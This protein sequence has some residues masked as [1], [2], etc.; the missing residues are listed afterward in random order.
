MNAPKPELEPDDR[1]PKPGPEIALPDWLRDQPAD[2]PAP[3]LPEAETESAS[4]TNTTGPIPA[5]GLSGAIPAWLHT[6]PETRSGRIDTS[7]APSIDFGNLIESSD[8]PLWLRRIADPAVDDETP[9]DESA[10][11]LP[12]APAL[13]VETEAAPWEHRFDIAAKTTEPETPPRVSWNLI[14]FLAALVAASVLIA[15]LALR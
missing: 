10:P 9:A 1:P 4:G 15:Y 3:N 6:P 12:N 5:D 14:L 8:L 7:T 13:P 2:R 11:E